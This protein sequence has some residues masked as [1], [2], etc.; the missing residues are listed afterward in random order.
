MRIYRAA[1]AV[2]AALFVIF[3]VSAQQ[4]AGSAANIYNTNSGNVGIGTSNP[5]SKLHIFSA[6]GDVYATIQANN[7]LA[8][9]AHL[10]LIGGRQ[11][12]LVGD[13]NGSGSP[14][15][16]P[17]GFVIRDSS[18]GVN[19]MVI[20]INGNVGL[21]T[22]NP[23]Y[24]FDVNGN[25]RIQSNGFG[26]VTFEQ[27]AY[28]NQGAL[29]FSSDRT[30]YTFMIGN[31]KNSDLSVLPII[32]MGDTGNVG[33]GTGTSVPVHKLSVNGT[34][35]ATE[36]IVAA[37]GADYV[38]QPGYRLAPLNEVAGYIE[39]NRHLPGI[40]AAAETERQ[41]VGLGEMQSKLLA[42]IEELT[43]HM[44]EAEKE[45]RELRLRM[46]RIENAASN[47][48]ASQ[49]SATFPTRQ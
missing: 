44:I 45:N 31:K 13:A 16:S 39:A 14:V 28:P 36:V 1:I 33:I 42:K 35:G 30:G 43:L 2:V 5:A 7:S 10:S 22:A 38:F 15:G 21:G 24:L 23:A 19:R 37:S 25:S 47:P 48:A 26:G 12:D 3:P 46:E 41:G 17:S 29:L 11:W 18:L 20:D 27:Q 9:G 32:T 4:W 34:I 40:P 6:A 8:Y 49:S